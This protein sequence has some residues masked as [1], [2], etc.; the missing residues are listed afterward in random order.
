MRLYN[1]VEETSKVVVVEDYTTF[2]GLLKSKYLYYLLIAY[3]AYAVINAALS[4]ID[5]GY[6]MAVINVL[7]HGS[8]CASFWMFKKA[9]D[10]NEEEKP[11]L[12]G[13]KLYL[14][15]TAVK[16]FIVFIFLVLGLLLIVFSWVG[17]AN[18]AKKE[19]VKVLSKTD[20]EAIAAAKLAKAN[21]F[22]SYLL[23][24]VFY[25][26]FTVFTLVYY[27]AV[28][29]PVDALNKYN[30]KGSHFWNDLKF[31]SI[32][33]FVTAGINV[34][35]GA[36][37]ALGLLDKWCGMMGNN[38]HN[39][40]KLAAGGLGWF[41]FISRVIFAALCACGGLVVLK[42]YKTLSTTETSHEEVIE[43]AE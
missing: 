18:E 20:L 6:L 37:G 9:N 29:A 5:G 2:K 26:A 38:G 8:I 14:V 16:Y 28:M 22:W 12:K 42:G 31:L 15:T 24:L 7:V 10:A 3:T 39:I 33:L 30:E 4:F 43:I 13:T 23:F 36:F 11:N 35:L 19:L 40:V 27:K 32:I 17:A 21:V 25:L 41:A 34:L 1:E